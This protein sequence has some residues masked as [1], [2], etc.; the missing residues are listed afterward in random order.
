MVPLAFAIPAIGTSLQ[1]QEPS[2]S[3][4]E[5][6]LQWLEGERDQMAADLAAAHQR[7]SARAER[8]NPA[9]LQRL[10]PTPPAP[11]PSGYGILPKLAADGP[12]TT[13]K[14]IER[15]YSLEWLSTAYSRD[16]RDAAILASQCQTDQAWDLQVAASELERLQGRK[17][18]LER[19]LSYH[20]WWQEAIVERRAYFDARNELIAQLRAAKQE[21][22]EVSP[23][24]LQSVYQQMAPFTPSSGLKIRDTEEGK[25]ILSVSIST[26]I[27]QGSFLEAFREAVERFWNQSEAA[28][29]VGLEIH[30]QIHRLQPQSL[31]PEGVPELGSKI[32]LRNH[33][34][35]F[36]PERFL[37]TTGAN[38]T[39]SWTGR[40]ILLGP[41]RITPRT[42]AHEFGHYL[43]FNDGY[44]RG[45]EGDPKDRFGVT[46][47]EW[48]GVA[49]DLM[50]NS[51]G[52]LVDRSLIDTLLRAYS[53]P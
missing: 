12:T 21:H 42:L 20:A 22:G 37:L 23:E 10:S 41:A 13:L 2:P 45:Y 5:F 25:K 17:G 50:A 49:N 1:E 40:S 30:V 35:R 7:L 51:S 38:S 48:T 3:L 44:L 18:Q 46:V 8:H 28:R 32:D 36:P 16:I 6:T 52:G 9:L 14:P 26:D 24:T 29:E 31:Y 34:D 33:M 19:S 39:H 47:V 53:E 11:L 43:G 27:E 15:R 4:R